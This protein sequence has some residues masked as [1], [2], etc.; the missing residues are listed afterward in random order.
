[1]WTPDIYSI[2]AEPFRARSMGLWLVGRRPVLSE[3]GYS[4]SPDLNNTF[5]RAGALHGSPFGRFMATYF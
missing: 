3:R 4:N 5:M 2:E 1:M